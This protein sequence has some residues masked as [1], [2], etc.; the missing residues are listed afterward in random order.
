MS[1]KGHAT[2][3]NTLVVG[4]WYDFWVHRDRVPAAMCKRGRL[5]YVNSRAQIAFFIWNGQLYDVPF[6][7]VKNRWKLVK[8]QAA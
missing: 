7:L 8:G 5:S 3:V 2:Y 1:K 4:E 6:H